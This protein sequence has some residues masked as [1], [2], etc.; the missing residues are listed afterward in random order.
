VRYLVSFYEVGDAR[1]HGAAFSLG[2]GF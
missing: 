2:L 1:P